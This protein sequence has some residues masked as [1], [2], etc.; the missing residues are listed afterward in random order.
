MPIDMHRATLLLD[1]ESWEAAR[2]L[3]DR[4]KCSVSQA[5]RR[6]VISHRDAVMVGSQESR[7]ERR[8]RV[9]RLIALVDGND[10][11]QEVRRLKSEDEGGF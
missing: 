4:Y 7:H 8:G 10:A 1:D 3:A 5:I 2:Q 9:E 6:A 11:E